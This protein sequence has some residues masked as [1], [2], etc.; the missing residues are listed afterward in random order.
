MDKIEN[1]QENELKLT[2]SCFHAPAHF[3]RL[4]PSGA[5]EDG[6]IK[7]GARGVKAPC[8]QQQHYLMKGRYS[9]PVVVRALREGVN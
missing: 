9:A 7:E 5:E 6:G 8:D 1:E 4:G 3:W 2:C